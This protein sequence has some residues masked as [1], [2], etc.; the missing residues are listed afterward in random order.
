MAEITYKVPN[1]HC[2]H[3]A[4]TIRQELSEMMGIHRVVVNVGQKV[5]TVDFEPPAS[6]G[7]IRGVLEEI[8]Y[9]ATP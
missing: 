5:V 7:Q 9:P 3:C 6:D 1:I 8:L 2:E 4:R